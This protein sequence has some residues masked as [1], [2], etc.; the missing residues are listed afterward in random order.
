MSRINNFQGRNFKK[1]REKDRQHSQEQEHGA[2][3]SLRCRKFSRFV[4]FFLFRQLKPVLKK[5][6][7]ALF[8]AVRPNSRAAESEQISVWAD[9]Y[10]KIRTALLR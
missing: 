3:D 7:N 4:F 8:S 9:L 2:H 10:R 1:Q 5:G 6:F